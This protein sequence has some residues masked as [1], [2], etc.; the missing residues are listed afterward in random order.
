MILINNIFLLYIAVYGRKG[1]TKNMCGVRVAGGWTQ[2]NG[3][4]LFR[5]ISEEW[6]CMH[7]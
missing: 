2:G 6:I 5:Y 4:E 1:E 3:G 7:G